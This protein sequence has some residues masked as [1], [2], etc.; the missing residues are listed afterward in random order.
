MKIKKR[1]D[2]KEHF[3]FLEL[4]KQKDNDFNKG[5]SIEITKEEFDKL[6]KFEWCEKVKGELNEHIKNIR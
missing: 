4:G 5:K 6:I 3:C 2:Y 1:K